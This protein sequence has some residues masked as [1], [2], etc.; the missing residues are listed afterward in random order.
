MVS[1]NIPRRKKQFQTIVDLKVRISS[2]LSH[3]MQ[4]QNWCA[5]VI[6]SLW[7]LLRYAFQG[8]AFKFKFLLSALSLALRVF[9]RCIQVALHPLRA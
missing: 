2:R 8:Q 5:H 6:P 1:L 4:P 7:P 3:A 9:S